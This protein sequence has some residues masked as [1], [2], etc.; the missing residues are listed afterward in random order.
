MGA[1]DLRS[2]FH[3]DSIAVIG[4]SESAGKLGHEILKNL[5]D[6]GFPGALHPI[7]P[8]SE[9]ILGLPC[10]R[11]VKEVPGQVDVAVVIIPARFVPQ[12]I[13]ECGEK[14]VKGAIVIS[15]GFS[16]AGADGEAL[17][18]ELAQAARECGVRVV[19]PNCQGINNPYHPMCASWPLLTTK[20]RVAVISQSGTVGAAMMDWFS[21]EGLGV[22]SF[23]SL[24][25]RADIDEID[26]I[27]YFEEDPETR[28]I[29]A[30]LEGVKDAVRFQEVLS[31][32]KKPLVVLKSGR[33]PKGKV[34]A[35]SHTKSLAGADAIYSSLFKRHGVCRAETIEEFYD[36]AKALAYLEP[37]RGNSI[38]YITTSGGAAILATDAAEQEG[39]NVAPLPPQL[40]RDLEGVIPAHAIRSNPLDLTGDADARMF[41]EVIERARP[42]YDTLGIIF[43]DPILDASQV[44]TPGANELVI[45]LGG[46]EVEREEK[47][48]MHQKGIPVYP[49]PER[50]IRALS[51]VITPALKEQK[52][53][54]TFPA[55]SGKSQLSLFESFRFLES[56][57]FDCIVSRIADSP[58]KAVHLAHQVGFP[59]ALKVDSPDILHKSDFGGVR[60]H[61][62]SAQD[63]R[64][65]YARMDEN[66]KAHAPG[67]RVNGVVVSAMAAP[68][69]ELILGMHRDPQFGPVILF[70]LGGIAVELFRD[71]AM[72][73]LPLTREDALSMLQEIKGAPLLR[74]FRGQRT[75]DENAL[76]EGLLKLARIAQDHPDIVEID[77]NPVLA[78]PEGMLVVDARILKG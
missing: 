4:A 78:Y 77:L 20:G 13:R 73:L 45:F 68:G 55:A 36:F 29:A 52:A 48:R 64:T 58:G 61:L 50:G 18:K 24:G 39:L 54:T 16:E 34:A 65:A 46:A 9:R 63:V 75:I 56:R 3:P 72:R 44:V 15:G 10:F 40:A 27:E 70:G 71:V 25:N 66:I 2:L 11:S 60:L 14:G 41:R 28:I 1:T 22:S 35:E 23:V 17:Q 49:T 12:T 74:G 47:L 42:H 67:A 38:L 33:T 6:G 59:V 19:G 7:N 32:L 31:R 8:K 53:L 57:G 26:L 62:L 69:L 30:Y 5:K 43:G 76:V 51:H 37:P 21:V